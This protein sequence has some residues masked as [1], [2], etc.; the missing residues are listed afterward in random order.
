MVFLIIQIFWMKIFLITGASLILLSISL[1][2][3]IVAKRYLALGFA[4]KIIADDSKLVKCHM[5]YAI[6][7]V[8]IFA[9][10]SIN[11]YIF[12]TIRQT[13]LLTSQ[14][15]TSVIAGY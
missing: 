9:F 15:Y 2:W 1:G 12:A 6:M 4:D 10:Y 5:E 13:M 14:V 3:L 11:R 8:I 7:A